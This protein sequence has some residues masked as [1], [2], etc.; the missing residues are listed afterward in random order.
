MNKSTYTKTDSSTGAK[1]TMRSAQPKGRAMRFVIKCSGCDHS[2]DHDFEITAIKAARKHLTDARK[3]GV[4][5]K[6]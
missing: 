4:H 5:A 2:E 3:S 1:V 6:A